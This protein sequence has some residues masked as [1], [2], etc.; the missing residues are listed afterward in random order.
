MERSTSFKLEPPAEAGDPRELW[1]AA[2]DGY[3]GE[4]RS[5]SEESFG[6]R[7][8]DW[9]SLARHLQPQR[10]ENEQHQGE[11]HRRQELGTGE[12]QRAHPDELA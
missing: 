5:C 1:F 9:D 4:L 11:G 7:F 8:P 10:P 6:E 12:G 3:L 2:R